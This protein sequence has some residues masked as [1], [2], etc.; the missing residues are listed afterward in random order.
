MRNVYVTFS[1]AAYDATTKQIAEKA[2]KLGA[3]AV[4]VYDD[5]WLM[6]Q[7]FR[8]ENDWAWR[9]PGHSGHKY[10]FGWYCWKPYVILHAMK[11]LKPGDCLLF[12]D[13]DTFPVS[14]FSMLFD[15]CR[16]EGGIFAFE[17]TGC[18]NRQW[19]KRD[20][21]EAVFAEMLEPVYFDRDIESQRGIILKALD[22]KLDTQHATARFMVFEKGAVRHRER[23]LTPEFFLSEWNR[24]CTTPGLTTRDP[25]SRPE[26][27]G[28]EENR[29]DQSIFS[30]L[31]L[32]YELPLH[33]EADEF[34]NGS[35]KDRELFGQ[36]FVQRY[37]AGDRNDLSG[38]RYRSGPE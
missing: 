14:N 10:G 22:Q 9:H 6:H 3:D 23:G 2:P 34:G 31:C 25:S 5:R 24:L 20:V 29:G 19:V 28:F 36:L 4:F 11:F 35:N 8:K 38:S 1:G 7:P 37:C 12:T 27:P 17:A 16:R 30:L 15:A 21:W 13:A 32:K 26:F 18:S 33:R